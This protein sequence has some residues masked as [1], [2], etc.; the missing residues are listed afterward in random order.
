MRP[1]RSYPSMNNPLWPYPRAPLDDRDDIVEIDFVDT[2]V[3]GDVDAFECRRQNG[4]DGVKLSKKDRGRE[5]EEGV[6][7]MSLPTSTPGCRPWFLGDRHRHRPMPSG[8]R[9]GQQPR[10]RIR[11]NRA[12]VKANQRNAASAPVKSWTIIH[13]RIGKGSSRHNEC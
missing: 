2:I 9:V 10:T 6:P 13:W 1:A 7:W 3:L 8:M 12:L 4:K 11:P 5:R